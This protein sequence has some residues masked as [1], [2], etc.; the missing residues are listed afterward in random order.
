MKA[1]TSALAEVLAQIRSDQAYFLCI[2]LFRSFADG[3]RET[4]V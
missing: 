3:L 4:V 2:E 1:A